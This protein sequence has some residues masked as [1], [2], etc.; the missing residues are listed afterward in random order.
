[1]KPPAF[2]FRPPA[3]PGLAPRLLAPLSA[4]WR[5]A[6]RR[7]WRRGPHARLDVPVVC[8]GNINV[9]GTGKT[10]TVLWL[11]Q[12]LASRGVA[13]HVV[14]RG[15][16]GRARGPLRVRE[17]M[18]AAEVGDE[19]LLLAAF[20][21][22]WIARDRLEGARAAQAAGAEMILLDDGLQNPALAKDFTLLVV[23]A[24]QG[25]GNGRVLPAGPLR[26]PVAEG[27]ARADAVLAIG[28]EAQRR[29]LLKTWPELA[30]HPLHAARL[31]PLQMG[32]DWEGLRAFAFAGIGRPE[33]FFETLRGL[34]A[35]LVGTRALPDHA[36]LSE[37]ALA[38]LA[39]EAAA[40]GA[41]LVTTEKDAARLPPA[42][43]GR[44]LT[45]PV[46]LVVDRGDELVDRILAARPA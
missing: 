44:V 2:W 34:G 17:G 3:R 31:E 40:K 21:P 13:V 42:W 30:H 18:D 4:L 43:R 27:L 12:E 7:R 9:G 32:M 41:Q 1:M 33:K 35:E 11:M 6:D 38:R 19:P 10:P 16:G 25:F 26:Q 46:R 39:R 22:T 37:A 29:A 36:A 15:Y 5:A 24:G 8:V 23:D 28:S 14:S 20:G 45:L